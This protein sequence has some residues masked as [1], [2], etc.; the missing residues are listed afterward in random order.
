MIRRP[1]RD[2]ARRLRAM[3][4]SAMPGI[5][6]G[7]FLLIGSAL[8][9]AHAGDQLS[10]ARIH[11]AQAPAPSTIDIRKAI[12]A[13]NTATSLLEDA[14]TTR[15]AAVAS[16]ARLD[17]LAAKLPI[18]ARLVSYNANGSVTV[19][20]LDQGLLGETATRW[21]ALGYTLSVSTTQLGEPGSGVS[22]P[23]EPNMQVTVADRGVPSSTPHPYAPSA[24]PTPLVHPAL[25]FSGVQR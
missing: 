13:V 5:V 16:V 21:A 4:V 25:P 24:M 1:R 3:L 6:G 23:I 11:A 17:H 8:A 10:I 20:A 7:L 14:I 9:R 19:E 22:A 12:T 2:G 15:D 18:G